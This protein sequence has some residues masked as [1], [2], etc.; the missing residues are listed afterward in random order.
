M[1]KL[2]L[3]AIFLFTPLLAS[4]QCAADSQCVPNAVIDRATAAAT[5]LVAARA[6]IE[7]FQNER[8]ATTAERESAARL[9]DRMNAVIS[10]QDRMSVEYE[11]A[12]TLYKK[13]LD[14]AFALIEKQS[15]MLNRGKS[16]WDKFVSAVKTV[17]TLATGVALGRGL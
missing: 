7:A 9:I 11:K 13:V 16:G 1:R 2:L 8:T 4:A 12:L 6:T 5:E 15:K 14:E 10:L 17:L 3:I